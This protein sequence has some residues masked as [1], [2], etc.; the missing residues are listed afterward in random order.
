MI[1]LTLPVAGYHIMTMQKYW[2]HMHYLIMNEY[3]SQT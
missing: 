2:A 1:L 3:E